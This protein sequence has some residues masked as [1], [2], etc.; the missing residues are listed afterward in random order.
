MAFHAPN[1]ELQVAIVRDPL[2]V[3]PTA[4]VLEAIA[5]MSGL[6]TACATT[7]RPPDYHQEVLQIAARSS[8][9]LVV[10]NQQCLGILTER[11]MVKLSLSSQP[12]DTL[13]V[14]TVM[15]P[16][17][18]TLR[19]SDFTDLFSALSLLQQHNFR[20]LPIVDEQ[21]HIVGL[22][23]QESLRYAVRPVEL[24]RLRTVAEVM[25]T[26]VVC[27]SPEDSL[28]S[29]SQLMA[30]YQISCIILTE[31]K[32]D[33]QLH[34]VGI[35]TERDIVQFHALNLN[36]D[37]YSA[38][39][40]MSTPVFTVSPMETLWTVKQ[41]M[42]QHFLSRIVVTG[43]EGELVGLVT[44]SDLLRL[45]NPLELYKL[46]EVLEQKVCQL[47][48]EKIHL[49]EEHTLTLEEKVQA[50]TA[51]LEKQ[52]RW[53][54]LLATIS[55]QIRSSLDVEEILD[56]TVQEV[57]SILTCD[58]AIIYQLYADFSGI[59]VAES[60]VHPEESV[61]H[62]KVDDPC[63]S[64]EWVEP[65]RQGKLRIV[66][67][68]YGEAMTLCHQE[69]L[70]AFGIRAKL[71]VPIVIQNQLWGLMIVSY[72]EN[73]HPWAEDE[74]ELVRQLGVQVSVAIQQ[75]QTYQQV[76]IE[77]QERQQAERALQ[78]LNQSLEERVRERTQA[79]DQ[80]DSELQRVSQR[81][82]VAVHA[83]E[84][85]IWEWEIGSDRIYW[86][87]RMYDLYGVSREQKE[88]YYETWKN[89]LHPQDSQSCQ[90]SIEAALA[91]QENFGGEFRVVHP[92]GTIRVLQ[93]FSLIQRDDQGQ[94]QRM[95]GVNVDIS[96]HK[97]AEIELQQTNQKLIRATQLKD[98]F[99][100]SMSH[101]LRTPLNAILGMTEGLQE[102]IFGKLNQ[103]QCK[104]L[105]TV[106]RSGTHLLELINDILD[107][108]KIEAGEFSLE[109][110]PTDP[111][112]LCVSSI[113]FVQRQAQKKQLQLQVD[114]SPNLPQLVVD[115]RRIR[116]VLINLLN[117]AVKFTPEGGEV[118]LEV[119]LL[120]SAFVR[121][122]IQD[123]GIGIAP[124]HQRKL[125]QPFVQIDSALNRQYAGTGLGLSLVKRVVELHGGTVGVSSEVGVGSQFAFEL[126][127]EPP[128]YD[129][130]QGRES[131][132]ED[133]VMAVG[134]ELPLILLAE[135]NPNNVFTI[136]SYLEAKGYRLMVAG[137]GQEALEYARSYHPQLILM[138]I[139]MPGMDGLT[140]IATLRND[141]M[142]QELPIIALTALAMDGDREQCLEA[143]AS[144]YLSKPVKLKQLAKMMQGFLNRFDS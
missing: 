111:N 82:E 25:V 15:T 90:E 63:V 91:G 50:R 17:P 54:K 29:L 71:M 57:R 60:T 140:A 80:R 96:D 38:Q 134:E 118:T 70:L 122:M 55:D 67:D 85:G 34:P 51:S 81:L 75:A 92:D 86:N 125:F 87:D 74:V 69:M 13:T 132:D 9:V 72:R 100:A 26:K 64:P 42:E 68:V 35:I 36:L 141:P 14:Q 129:G 5:Q 30:D 121:F 49:L 2:Q 144:A 115:E 32:T 62:S 8:C 27:G 19:E 20:H 3:A 84:L 77:L 37:R 41:R 73:P 16:T 28:R 116:Q 48:Q 24:L 119:R 45:L 89:C 10:E 56:R 106:E 52:A 142:F 103:K 139:Q 31:P 53:G 59:V 43:Q 137:D 78:D 61:L 109:L 88:V 101:E 46:M 123:T 99:L 40:V 93:A 79:L 6:Q 4:T 120:S 18:I 128:H 21:G 135:D 47:E 107:L 117:N 23:T 108:S 44:Q 95:I 7:P 130:T 112:I 39:T 138:D 143:G 102:E 66:N 22:V 76:Q 110:K 136:T 58:R 11:D 12:L 133:E 105:Q 114:V 83:A 113:E 94:P 1:P 33:G 104:A 65:Y 126:P 98:E 127:Y 131:F 124:E 97:A